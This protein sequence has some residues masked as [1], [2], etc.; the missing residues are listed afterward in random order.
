MAYELTRGPAWSGPLGVCGRFLVPLVAILAAACASAGPTGDPE[1]AREPRPREEAGPAEPEAP[2]RSELMDRLDVLVRRGEDS[3]VVRLADSLYFTSR[4][5]GETS[6][7]VEALWREARS[8]ARLGETRTAARRL[9]ELLRTHPRSERRDEAALELATLRVALGDDPGAVGT[10]L[11]HPDA[12]DD[13][14]LAVLRTATSG[15]S[16]PE[17]EDALGSVGTESPGGVVVRAELAFALA[18]AGR[19]EAAREM[20]SSVVD[21]GSEEPERRRARRVLDGAVEPIEGPPSIGVL[22]P[23]TGRLERVGGWILEGMRLAERGVLSSTVGSGPSGGGSGADSGASA[24]PA[25]ELVV[26][27][28]AGAEGLS[29]AVARLEERGVV[30]IV[31]GVRSSDLRA[32][33][34]GRSGPGLL[35][36]SPTATRMTAVWP[37]VYT[38]WDAR[39]RA[40]DGARALGRWLSTEAGIGEAAALYPRGEAGARSLLAFRSGIAGGPGWLTAS[41]SYATDTTDF[42]GPI[43]LVGAFDPRA[44]FVVAASPNTVLQLAPQLSYYGMRSTVVAGDPTWAEPSALRRLEPSFTQ[45]RLVAS[46]LDRGVEGSG[47]ERFRD[48]YERAQRRGLGNNVLPALGHDALLLLQRA[49]A[50]MSLPRP[51]A[52]ARRFAALA[53][54]EGATGTLGPRRWEGTVE[55]RA[56]VRVV[57]ERSLAPVEGAEVS[58][59]LEG[60]ERISDAQRRRRRSA[61]LEAVREA[62]ERSDAG[63]DEGSGS[64]SDAPGE[65]G[66]G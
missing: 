24:P 29:A 15:M 17:L 19:S 44:V 53:E 22:V 47:W 56:T 52:L 62:V 26:E 59:W 66:D 8:L 65:G 41:A 9:E 49:A 51:R 23:M 30:A 14:A 38:L 18:R 40:L 27:D 2:S 54:I 12:V 20:A 33:S 42:E 5:A 1:E 10:L 48:A 43:D 32:L 55:R 64:G 3:R 45:L 36:V 16:I 37:D 46:L 31:G 34:E 28:A 58:E 25:F 63:G 35:I 50:G 57:R 61:A 39:R 60:A 11:D 4:D 21:A 7:A 6:D 13:S